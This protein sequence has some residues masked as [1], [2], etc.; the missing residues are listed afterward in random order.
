MFLKSRLHTIE[1]KCNSFARYIKNLDSCRNFAR[2]S[3]TNANTFSKLGLFYQHVK[4][5]KGSEGDY[6]MITPYSY[7]VILRNMKHFKV[8]LAHSYYRILHDNQMNPYSIATFADLKH[9]LQQETGNGFDAIF[10]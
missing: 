6:K 2:L 7:F 1:D 3:R 8:S 5:L 9:K 10:Q 4:Y